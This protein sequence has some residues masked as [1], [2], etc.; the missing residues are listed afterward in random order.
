MHNPYQSPAEHSA[1][2]SQAR[3]EALFRTEAQIRGLGLAFGVNALAG[4]SLLTLH[5]SAWVLGLMG[6]AL[7]LLIPVLG[8]VSG[9]WGFVLLVTMDGREV[10]SPEYALVRARSS[11]PPW[12]PSWTALKL[13][14]I[15]LLM[16]L[17]LWSL[18]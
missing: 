4:G 16:S 14:F 9:P 18:A 6:S 3:R 5:R 11:A 2:A 12:R 13:A 15:G 17:A 1:E 7:S 10:C 8:W